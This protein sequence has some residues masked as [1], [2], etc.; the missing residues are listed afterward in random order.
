[1]HGVTISNINRRGAEINLI[2]V[3]GIFR[4][5]VAS[6][7]WAIAGVEALGADSATQL[8]AYSDEEA[9]IDGEELLR[10]ASEV[11]QVIDG[12]FTGFQIAQDDPWII[13]YAVDSSSYDVLTDEQAVLEAIRSRFNDVTDIP[14]D[15]HSLD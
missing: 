10:L 6:S 1:M 3:L 15:G 9:T 12:N 5:R 2:D 14:C 7:S 8:N 4:D 11:T 13:I